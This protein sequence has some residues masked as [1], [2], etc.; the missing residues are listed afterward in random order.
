MTRDTAF[1]SLGFIAAAVVATVI[2]RLLNPEP[3]AETP[4][5]APT[6]FYSYGTEARS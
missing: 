5:V 2:D 4:S 3:R 1:F 6:P